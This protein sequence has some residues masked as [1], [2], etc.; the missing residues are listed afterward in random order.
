MLDP[1]SVMQCYATL[2]TPS[3]HAAGR[4]DLDRFEQAFDQLPDDYREAITLKRIV[5]LDYAE[6]AKVMGRAEGAV[7]NLVYRGL[8]R[9]SALLKE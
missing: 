7:R 8:G 2:C 5:G 9:L 4:E 1:A 3:R 6:I